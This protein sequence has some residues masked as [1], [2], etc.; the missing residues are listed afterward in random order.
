M[1]AAAPGVSLSAFRRSS[2]SLAARSGARDLILLSIGGKVRSGDAFAPAP[3]TSR[4]SAAS[5]IRA[6]KRTSSAGPEAGFAPSPAASHTARSAFSP[7]R[8]S[9]G[10]ERREGA[11]PDP[12]QATAAS[13]SRARSAASPYVASRS[14]GQVLYRLAHRDPVRRDRVVAPHPSLPSAGVGEHV[15]QGLEVDRIGRKQLGVPRP[16][17]GLVPAAPART[18]F[19]AF[20]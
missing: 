7:S 9:R 12:N 3:G 14:G 8:L 1:L 19:F 13:C 6:T 20:M 4:S 16:G 11:P 2:Q 15:G 17:E 10:V 5:A 18:L